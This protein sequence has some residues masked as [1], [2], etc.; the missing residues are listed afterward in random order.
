MKYITLNNGVEIP[1]VGCG[2]NTF[3]KEENK[4]SG[5]LR[6]D[7]L[8]IDLAIE[9][10]YRHFDCAQ[11][12]RNE[13]VVGNGLKKFSLPREKFFITSKLNTYKGFNGSDWAR[14]EIEKSLEK[15]QTDYIDLFLIH[16]PWDNRDEMLE[17]WKV[18]EEYYNR[19][20]F[21]A[22]GVSN[23]KKEHL[24]LILENSNIK[25]AV[26]QIESHVGKWNDE[27]IAYNKNHNI[28]TVAWSPLRG[29][30]ED[31]K[32]VLT[33]IGQQYEKTPAQMVLRYQIER[34]V[35]VIPKSHHKE[36]QAQNLDIFDFELTALD[37]ERIASL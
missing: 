31:A 2:T 7:T 20:V 37:R 16:F 32:Q 23:F 28:A 5:A 3:G 10:G 33:E 18:L 11:L 34:D 1:I 36:R 8:E 6:G 30:D 35:I 9:N 19:G 25:P 29:I 15:L 26:N 24:D 17:A 12:Y 27:L 4:Y 22:I 13:E 14:A 21:K